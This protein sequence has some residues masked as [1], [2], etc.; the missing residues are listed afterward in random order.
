MDVSEL[1]D[2]AVNEM[3]DFDESN[4]ETRTEKLRRLAKLMIEIRAHFEDSHGRGPDWLGRSKEYRLIVSEL[5]DKL[6][7]SVNTKSR[8]RYHLNSAIRDRLTEEELD[9]YGLREASVKDRA[10]HRIKSSRAIRPAMTTNGLGESAV[11]QTIHAARQA[12]TA[13][14]DDDVKTL[15]TKEQ[16]E[17][18]KSELRA[19][20]TRSLELLGADA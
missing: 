1:F 19:I 13:L 14:M 20:I 16:R 15:R 11:C 8:L 6:G 3:Q 2:L 10:R 9:A 12:L 5:F 7:L 4:P 17:Y 18:A